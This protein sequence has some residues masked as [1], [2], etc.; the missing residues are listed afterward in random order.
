MKNL[1]VL[2]EKYSMGDGIIVSIFSMLIVFLILLLLTII[3]MLLKYIPF[4]DTEKTNAKPVPVAAQNDAVTSLSAADEEE[5]MVAMLAASCLAKD[6][7]DGD[8]RV[9]SVERTK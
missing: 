8:V 1:I 2:L 6:E 9:V 3:V 4:K 5:R 7:I